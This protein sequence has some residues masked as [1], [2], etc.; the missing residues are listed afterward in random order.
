MPYAGADDF[1]R[2]VTLTSGIALIAV[3]FLAAAALPRRGRAVAVLA[4][5]IVS[6]IPATE[7]SATSPYLR[8]ALR[9]AGRARCCG[10]EALHAG[11]WAGFSRS[12]DR[13]DPG[14]A[15]RSRR[16]ALGPALDVRR[17]S[18]DSDKFVTN[19]TRSDAEQF[20]LKPR[21]RRWTGRATAVWSC[22]SRRRQSSYWKAANLR[23]VEHSRHHRLVQAGLRPEQRGPVRTRRRRA[24][25]PRLKN[26]KVNLTGVRTP[27]RSS[28]RAPRCRSTG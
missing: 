9:A 11:G 21:L 6:T 8:G 19:L 17:P 7:T 22:A 24:P 10:A 28:A 27:T 1:V 18:V 20:F 4:L 26:V 3:A 12:A 2:L 16:L 5:A 23:R 13:G 15:R 14:R 25:A